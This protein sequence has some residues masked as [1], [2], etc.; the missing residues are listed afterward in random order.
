M[1]T[2]AIDSNILIDILFNDQE[3]GSP[4]S[5]TLR[6]GSKEPL[7]LRINSLLFGDG[8]NRVK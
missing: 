8:G 7:L 6:T 4:D 3:F 2:T 5:A 1:I